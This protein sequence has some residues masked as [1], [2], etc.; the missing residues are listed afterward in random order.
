MINYLILKTRKDGDGKRLQPLITLGAVKLFYSRV[1]LF[2][3]Q[4]PATGTY[5]LPGAGLSTSL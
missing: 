5:G 2:K 4:L 1:E 3:L